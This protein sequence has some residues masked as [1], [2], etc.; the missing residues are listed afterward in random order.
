[1]GGTNGIGTHRV[2]VC[3]GSNLGDK[4]ENCRN[5]ILEVARTTGSVLKSRSPLY[6]TEPVDFR[7]QE[8]FVNGVAEFET[9]LS[10][11]ALL[12]ALKQI[13][14][15]AGRTEGGIRFGPRVLDLDIIFYGD[16]V[17]ETGDLAIPHPRM[18]QRRFVLR[19]M[20]DIAPELVHPVLKKTMRDLF[21]E[22]EEPGQKV[23]PYP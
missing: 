11:H 14:R 5:G 6:R 2:F 3:A 20:R 19:P 7:D 23:T 13:E 18:H 8:W 21:A 12:T 10:P 9:A 4:A 15:R 22:I 16:A 17:I 1:M